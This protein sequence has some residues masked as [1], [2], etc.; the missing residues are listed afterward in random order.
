MTDVVD[1]LN[2]S[3]IDIET[4]EPLFPGVFAHC[5]VE[6]IKEAVVEIERLREENRKLEERITELG[7]ITS[8][9][10]MGR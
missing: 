6:D 3:I 9:E 8:P 7:W 1:R 2:E 4:N 5:T 10:R